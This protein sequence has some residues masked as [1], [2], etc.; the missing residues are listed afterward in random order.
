[1][2]RDEASPIAHGGCHHGVVPRVCFLVLSHTE[3]DLVERLVRT[4]V[5]EVP[6]ASVVVRHDARAVDFDAQRV[7][8][9]PRVHVHAHRED[10]A[11]GSWALTTRTLEGVEH[12]LALDDPWD[13]LVLIS[14]QSYPVRPLDELVERLAVSPSDALL[15]LAAP[16]DRSQPSWRRWLPNGADRARYRFRRLPWTPLW[17]FHHVRYPLTHQAQRQPLA[18]LYFHHDPR[19]PRRFIAH[20]VHL[21]FRS[22]FT[23]AVVP[24][25]ASQWWVARRSAART[26]LSLLDRQ[27]PWHRHFRH[28]FTSDELAIPSLLAARG[29]AV[30][31]DPLHAM[32]WPDG[33][34]PSTLTTEDLPW[35]E[36]RLE[37][38]TRKV[39]LADDGDL[40]DALDALRARRSSEREVVDERS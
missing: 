7:A 23:E 28:T 13:W 26:M 14:G 2:G 39:S 30:E 38:F 17:E 9:L 12:A 19:D 24:V 8:D 35:L 37:F 6:D 18:A 16:S 31:D 40:I 20:F 1:M 22:L 33:P 34:S 29:F 11:W 32:W 36:K 21:P 5:A 15:H 25:K 4:L 27:D 3:P 10:A